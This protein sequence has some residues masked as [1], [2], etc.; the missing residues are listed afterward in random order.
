[1]GGL[2]A[3]LRLYTLIC[4]CTCIFACMRLIWQI[5]LIAPCVIQWLI[6]AKYALVLTLQYIYTTLQFFHKKNIVQVFLMYNEFA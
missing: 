2:F 5:W 4:D 6:W 3:Y 1:M